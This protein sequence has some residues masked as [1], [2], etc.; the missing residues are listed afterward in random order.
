MDNRNLQENN[1]EQNR[2]AMRNKYSR[3]AICVII[4]GLITSG[5]QLLNSYVIAP[6]LGIDVDESSWYSFANILIPMH[7]VSFGIFLSLNVKQETTVP[8]KHDMS[9]GR[10]L[11]CIPLMAGLAGAGAIVGFILNTALTLPFGVNPSENTAIAQIM[12][13]SNPFWRILVAGITA[14]IVEELVFRK[15]LI[16]RVL[17]YG[18][19]AAI[20]TSGLM[21]GLFHGN[22]AQFFFAS[23][24]GMFFAFIYVRTGKI[25]YTIVLHA[26]MNLSTSVITM[27]TMKPYLS[28]DDKL[29]TQSQDLSTQYFSSGGNPAVEQQLMEVA[30]QVLPKMVPYLVWIGFLGQLALAGVV[31][32]II[33]L[34]KKKFTLKPTAAQVEGGFKTAW[35]NPG[36]ILFVIYCIVEFVMNYISIIVNAGK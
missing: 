8:E 14:P 26:T 24:I 1:R 17:K 20:L 15:L 7:I 13:D 23:L 29:L 28:V 18:E 27:L 33:L 30:G 25:Q 32:L 36:M 22:F 10:F 21:F 5:L 35:G 2:L 11:L 34:A 31:I 16:D 19:L 4:F 3:Y 12:M 9:I 6:K